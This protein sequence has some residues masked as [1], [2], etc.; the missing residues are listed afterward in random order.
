M[1]ELIITDNQAYELKI[2]FDGERY[3]LVHF[4]KDMLPQ[5][6]SIT[7]TVLNPREAQVAAKFILSQPTSF[8]LKRGGS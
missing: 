1:E 3:G 7:T 5:W 6:R 8:K 2:K 4:D